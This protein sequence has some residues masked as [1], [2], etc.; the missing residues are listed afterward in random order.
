MRLLKKP[1]PLIPA[2]QAYIQKP[3][4]QCMS[5]ASFIHVKHTGEGTELGMTLHLSFIVKQVET[6][7]LTT[8]SDAPPRTLGLTQGTR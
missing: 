4:C 6:P 2:P 1:K 7:P 3:R 8:S 5:P